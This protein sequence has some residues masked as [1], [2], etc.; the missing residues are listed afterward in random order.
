MKKVYFLFLIVVVFNLILLSSTKTATPIL[1]QGFISENVLGNLI[2]NEDLEV[3]VRTEIG[4]VTYANTKWTNPGGSHTV[5]HYDAIVY[6]FPGNK[7]TVTASIKGKNCIAD[8]GEEN[9]PGGEVFMAPVRESMSGWINFDYPRIIDGNFISGV[10][11][12]FEVNP[13]PRSKLS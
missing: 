1:V 12:K 10:K 9:M 5:G 7:I 13:G 6:A 8:K 4:S 3:I 11:L 2:D